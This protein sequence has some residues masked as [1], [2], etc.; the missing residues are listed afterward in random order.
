M[1]NEK[2][3]FVTLEKFALELGFSFFGVADITEIQQDFH[4]ESRVASKYPR[5]IS[6]GKK[7][8][9]SVLDT[10]KNEPNAVYFHHYR[11]IN[12]FL[13]RGA[14]LLSTF[15]QEQGFNALPIAASQVIDWEK[16]I[17]HVSH[18][19][20]AQL[21]GLGWI[22]RNNLLVT[23]EA[24]SGLR[25]VTILTDMPLECGAPVPFSCGECTRCISECPAQAI[26]ADPKNFN[27]LA[28]FEKLKEFRKRGLV[29]QYICGVCVRACPGFNR[30]S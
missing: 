25:L 12:F 16:Q 15:I 2:Q 30:L 28:C 4:I 5:G 8:L 29:G 20:I 3:N 17:G 19:K 18:K 6:L 14:L 1:Q 27:H 10:I 24:G 21:A 26:D 7:L 9:D 23:K 11:Q 13:D 22:G